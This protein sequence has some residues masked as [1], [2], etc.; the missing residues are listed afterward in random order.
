MQE[1]KPKFV[2]IFLWLGSIHGGLVLAYAIATNVM[3]SRAGEVSSDLDYST[4]SVS[5][6]VKF[7]VDYTASPQNIGWPPQ[8]PLEMADGA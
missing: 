5:D 2:R 7:Q 8:R 3:M 4:T 1:S 6:N